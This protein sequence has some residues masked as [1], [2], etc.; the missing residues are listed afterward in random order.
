MVSRDKGGT[1]TWASSGAGRGGGGLTPEVAAEN[2]EHTWSKVSALQYLQLKTDYLEV[3]RQESQAKV[4]FPRKVKGS[5]SL[6]VYS[7][8]VVSGSSQLS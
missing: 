8:C 4:V 1:S 3:H 6:S 2:W 5:H 7:K